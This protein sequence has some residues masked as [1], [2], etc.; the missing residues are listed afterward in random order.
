MSFIAAV[1]FPPQNVFKKKFLVSHH[2][3]FMFHARRAFFH[4]RI[5]WT[6][7]EVIYGY[8]YMAAPAGLC[9]QTGS[10]GR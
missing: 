4:E 9:T 7:T 8:A 5:Q 3:K 6:A 10:T 1:S 2:I